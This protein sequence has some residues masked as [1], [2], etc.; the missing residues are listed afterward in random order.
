MSTLWSTAVRRR[1][2]SVVGAAWFAVGILTAFLVAF[3]IHA[4]DVDPQ[5]SRRLP[6]GEAV[7][8]RPDPCPRPSLT[9]V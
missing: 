2:R 4:H 5:L 8:D 3:V 6:V 1:H 7:P 9:Q